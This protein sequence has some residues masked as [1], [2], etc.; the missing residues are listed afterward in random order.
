MCSS[1]EL[2]PLPGR[3]SDSLMENVALIDTLLPVH[4]HEARKWGFLNVQFGSFLLKRE[5]NSIVEFFSGNYNP[6][7]SHYCL[8]A[9]DIETFLLF[10]IYSV[11]I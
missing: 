4:V 11:I 9:R 2:E 3:F 6:T 5:R 1:L 10:V 8:V 7:S